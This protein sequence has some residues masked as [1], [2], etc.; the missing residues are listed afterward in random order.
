[1]K[2]F[3]VWKEPGLNCYRVFLRVNGRSIKI[4]TFEN[5]VYY[6]AKLGQDWEI[7]EIT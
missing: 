6:G 5:H 3:T 4:T 7:Y 2:Y 1:M